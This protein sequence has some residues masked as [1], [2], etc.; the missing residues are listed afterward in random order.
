MSASSVKQS[1]PASA[2]AA[3][4]RTHS[5]HSADEQRTSEIPARRAH[6][7]QTCSTHTPNPAQQKEKKSAF[8]LVFSFS[9]PSSDRQCEQPNQIPN[10]QD[11]ILARLRGG[12][13][14]RNRILHAFVVLFVCLF[15]SACLVWRETRVCLQW[16]RDHTPLLNIAWLLQCLKNEKIFV[17]LRVKW[18]LQMFQNAGATA[19]RVSP[20]TEP[21]GTPLVPL[22]AVFLLR[23][24]LMSVKT[25]M[26]DR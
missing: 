6:T 3:G 12:R 4:E 5:P 23:G 10:F 8:S 16:E 1:T 17:G 7:A 18:S 22:T 15:V 20:N 21:C 24:T 25:E 14:S 26:T 11:E 13:G 9:G 19:A 2:G